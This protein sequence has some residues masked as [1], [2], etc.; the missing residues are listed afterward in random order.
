LILGAFLDTVM[1]EVSLSPDAV[2]VALDEVPE[3]YP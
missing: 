3:T 2:S 1:L